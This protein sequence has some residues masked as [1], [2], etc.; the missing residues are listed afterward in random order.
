MISL[1]GCNDY[2]DSMEINEMIDT[3]IGRGDTDVEGRE[4]WGAM[5]R[6][7]MDRVV[8]EKNHAKN[9]NNTYYTHNLGYCCQFHT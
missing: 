4:N 8:K 9:N 3:E 2:E 7:R 5:T 1:S 6:D